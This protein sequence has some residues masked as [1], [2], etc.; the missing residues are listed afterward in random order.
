MSW[1]VSLICDGC[2]SE[3]IDQNYTHN[4]S[5]MIYTVL[6]EDPEFDQL[7]EHE[8]WYKR[9]DG[10]SGPEGAAFLHRIIVGLK[11]DPVR[12]REMNPDNGWGNYDQLVDILTKMRDRVPEAPTTWRGYG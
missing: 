3:I 5:K 2:G 9:L 6:R 12:F 10:M 8:S 1:D 4:T 11:A 7:A